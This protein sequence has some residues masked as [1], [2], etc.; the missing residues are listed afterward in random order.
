MPRYCLFGDT[1][2]T[3][4]R[5]ESHGQPLKIH[6]S[7]QT[8]EHLD[9]FGNYILQSRGLVQI[10]GKGNIETFWLLGHKD[11]TARYRHD[12]SNK[13]SN[14]VGLFDAIGQKEGKKKSPRVTHNN[15]LISGSDL[16]KLN[17]YKS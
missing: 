10:K 13:I 9:R 8:K 7:P 4:S 1:V 12:P 14:N 3:A 6:T 17:C 11:E 5:M 2:N 15:S 16:F